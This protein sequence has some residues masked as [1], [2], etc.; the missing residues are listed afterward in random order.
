M[1]ITAPL[2][3]IRHLPRT[4]LATVLPVKELRF[5]SCAKDNDAWR[6]KVDGLC[7]AREFCFSFIGRHNVE[8]FAA[9]ALIAHVA[10][11]NWDDI[12]AAAAD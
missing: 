9:A 8:N 3:E 6:V 2:C 5:L 12:E 7:G 1:M 4:Y 10:G 11:V